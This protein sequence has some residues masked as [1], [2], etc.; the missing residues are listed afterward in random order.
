MKSITTE[1]TEPP[2]NLRMIRLK[3]MF[4]DVS[5]DTLYD[6]LHDPVY[7]KVGHRTMLIRTVVDY[8]RHGTST[9]CPHLNWVSSTLTMTCPTTPYIVLPLLKTE[10]LSSRDPG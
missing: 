8:P 4:T 1:L 3:T 2:C 6:V 7:R 5:G 9:C 10:T